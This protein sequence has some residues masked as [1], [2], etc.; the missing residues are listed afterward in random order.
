ME[1]QGKEE[2]SGSEMPSQGLHEQGC[3][4]GHTYIHPTLLSPMPPYTFKTIRPGPM[5]LGRPL[6][7]LLNGAGCMLS[8]SL[9]PQE[10]SSA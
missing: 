8:C 7:R 9:P 4:G 10:S 5:E 1:K 3:H 2:R 6:N